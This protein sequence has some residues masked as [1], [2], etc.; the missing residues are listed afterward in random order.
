MGRRRKG[1]IWDQVKELVDAGKQPVITLTAAQEV[2]VSKV[3]DGPGQ[4]KIP[5]DPG[6][7]R[8]SHYL[9][10]GRPIRSQPR[11]YNRGCLNYLR[12]DDNMVCSEFCKEEVIREAR[13][14]L[15]R[16]EGDWVVPMPIVG[17]G[18]SA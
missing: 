12:R 18:E 3:Q 5:R 8:Y 14:V 9:G 4:P 6:D 17:R 2:R 16:L 7:H 15:V 10:N 11:C 13:K 1:G